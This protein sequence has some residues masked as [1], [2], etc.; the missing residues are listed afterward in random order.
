MD[1]FVFIIIM[2][3]VISNLNGTMGISTY[4]VMTRTYVANVPTQTQ[5]GKPAVVLSVVYTRVCVCLCVCTQRLFTIFR[6]LISG[7]FFFFLALW[8]IK[9]FLYNISHSI[10]RCLCMC[11]VCAFCMKMQ[12]QV[13]L[14]N[15]IF[16]Y[17]LT[18]N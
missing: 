18:K 3:I 6:V 1:V 9:F 8:V 5:L 17:F 12:I 16:V 4:C 14:E 13:M 11:S 10:Q 7:Y 15:C 2:M